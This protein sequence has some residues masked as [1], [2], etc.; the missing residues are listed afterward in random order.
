MQYRLERDDIL[1]R[2]VLRLS[3]G[4]YFIL[5][6][7]VTMV[8][9]PPLKPLDFE[10]LSPR[11]AKLIVQTRK[12]APLP[13]TPEVRVDPGK[14]GGEEPAPK[15][16]PP[17]SSAEKSQEVVKET[18]R[19]AVRKSGLLAS[20]IKEQEGGRLGKL[21]ESPQLS[22]VLSDVKLI[23]TPTRKSGRPVIQKSYSKE[24]RIADKKIAGLGGLSEGDRVTLEK[25]EGVSLGSGR[26]RGGG[27]GG[28]SGGGGHGL[29][30]GAGVRVKGGGSGGNAMIDYDAIARVVD[31][32]K[33]SLVY[34]YNKELRG[35]PTLKGTIT[36]EF[37]IDTMGKVVEVRVVSSTME[38]PPLEEALSRR[39]Q[40]WKFPHLYDGIIIVTYPFIFFPL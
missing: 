2:K 34:L 17:G 6:A 25:G 4:F 14:G 38:H 23:T 24:S 21:I 28:G 27:S 30:D 33:S 35:N 13:V 22:G 32:Y 1:F 20:L 40:M 37:S 8:H 15:E 39:I 9:L 5:A 10:A 19:E 12:A 16:E 29:G 18:T 31:Q 26:G 36:V 11:I 3:L 7:L